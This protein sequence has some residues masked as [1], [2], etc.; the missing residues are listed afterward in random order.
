MAVEV[1]YLFERPDFVDL[2]NAT[3]DENR[4]GNPG[5][6]EKDYFVTEA[7]RLIARDFGDVVI[8]KGGTSLS[9]GWKLIDRF[10]EDIDL[11]V[12]PA[13]SG[14][15]T[16]ARFEQVADLV[17][18]FPG[19]VGR[20][21]RQETKGSSSWTEEFVYTSRVDSLG[22]IRPVVLLEA[23]VQSADQ[24]TENRKLSSLIGE[25]LDSQNV[26]SGTAD[27]LPFVMR[28]LHFR[29]TFVEKLFTLHSRVERAK[30]QGKD[31]G[32][33]AR[34]YYDLA[35]LLGEP[36]TKSMLESDEFK[37]ICGQYRDLTAKFYPGQVKLLPDGMN[38]SASSAFFPDPELRAMLSSAY[39]READTLCYGPYPNFDEILESFEGIQSLLNIHI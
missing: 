35:M 36:Q 28:L 2:V 29:R 20:L 23:G 11:Y 13:E 17:A 25:M 18:S 22:G 9:K 4:I 34:H 33:D 7:L 32:R 15:A 27:R 6:V 1:S 24:P 26:E 16:L 37:V 30:K 21:G 38:L 31:L 14:E 19:F 5:I 12:E 3:G 39:I 8:F 10:S